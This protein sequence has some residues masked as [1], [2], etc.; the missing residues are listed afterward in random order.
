MPSRFRTLLIVLT[1]CPSFMLGVQPSVALPTITPSI[2]T[3]GVSTIRVST[4]I[5]DPNGNM[6]L[7][8]V[9]VLQVDQTGKALSILG[10][11]NDSG[12]SSDA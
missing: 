6:L 7:N 2:I 8:G 5:Y 4:L 10:A 1:G 11:L 3:G 12:V 9:N